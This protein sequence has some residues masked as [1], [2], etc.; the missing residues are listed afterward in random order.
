M[1]DEKGC[2]GTGGPMSARTRTSA[3]ERSPTSSPGGPWATETRSEA[4]SSPT[5]LDERY[6]RM[7]ASDG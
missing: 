3:R 7:D 4:A 6:E 1:S 5:P 2:G